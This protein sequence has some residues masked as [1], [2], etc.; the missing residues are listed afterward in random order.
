MEVLQQW[1]QH[2][3][4]V[5]YR[6]RQHALP[7]PGGSRAADLAV[8]RTHVDTKVDRGVENGVRHR[9]GRSWDG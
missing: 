9:S 8:T 3:A 5:R 6:L 4:E 1:G 2:R 7:C